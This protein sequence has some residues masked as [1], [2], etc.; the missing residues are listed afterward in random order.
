MSAAS[1]AMTAVRASRRINRRLTRWWML[2]NAAGATLLAARSMEFYA[3]AH[4]HGY[5]AASWLLA[6]LAGWFVL[7]I[8]LGAAQAATCSWAFSRVNIAQRTLRG[9]LEGFLGLLTGFLFPLLGMAIFRMPD[10]ALGAWIFAPTGIVFGW[11]IS[12]SQSASHPQPSAAPKIAT[13]ARAASNAPAKRQWRLNV[14]WKPTL[15]W[16]AVNAAGL[17]IAV[18]LS[19]LYS[20][21]H[22]DRP[23]PGF[24]ALN[25]FLLLAVL[26]LL[27]AVAGGV[28]ISFVGMR[29]KTLRIALGVTLGLLTAILVLILGMSFLWIGALLAFWVLVPSGIL[30]GWLCAA[31]DPTP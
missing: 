2:V 22:G 11:L 21:A 13:R 5:H 14:H 30:F 23:T 31:P 27:H 28:L 16:I 1:P 20:V 26:G 18:A 12:S 24:G 19:E 6:S 10:A 15:W 9:I 17:A 8:A 29:N 4:A 7:T 3:M 25:F